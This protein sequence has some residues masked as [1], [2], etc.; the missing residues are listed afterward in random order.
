VLERESLEA[1]GRLVDTLVDRDLLAAAVSAVLAGAVITVFTWLAEAAESDLTR[2]FIALAVN[3]V[4]AL[5]VD[6]GAVYA[7]GEFTTIGS[8]PRQGFAQFGT[9]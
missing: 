5:A 8:K 1:A 3:T 4:H 2:L 9:P 7:G 6:G